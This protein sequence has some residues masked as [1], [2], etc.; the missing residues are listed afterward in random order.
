MSSFVNEDIEKLSKNIINELKSDSIGN[1]IKG[2]EFE[3]VKKALKKFFPNI[4]LEGIK[5]NYLTYLKALLTDIKNIE[6]NG[7]ELNVIIN[8]LKFETGQTGQTG[9]TG[10]TTDGPTDG[11][12]PLKSNIINIDI[13]PIANPVSISVDGTVFFSQPDQEDQSDLTLQIASRSSFLSCLIGII[14]LLCG[15]I[16]L[17][18]NEPDTSVIFAGQTLLG[19]SFII[20]IIYIFHI[21]Y[22]K[23]QNSLVQVAADDVEANIIVELDQA[24]SDIEQGVTSVGG[25]RKRKNKKTKRKNSKKRKLMNFSL[26]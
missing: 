7:H 6:Y 15:Y 26:S 2:I 5:S 19:S 12:T 4:N 10:G 24:L 3:D 20:T 1:R 23:R 9:Q 17:E 13:I 8:Q 18:G 22:K 21:C 25:K 14:L 11:P 16:P